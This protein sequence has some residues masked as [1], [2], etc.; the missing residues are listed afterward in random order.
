MLDGT[1]VAVDGLH[2]HHIGRPTPVYGTRHMGA[3]PCGARPLQAH[4]ETKAKMIQYRPA[5]KTVLR[6]NLH[7]EDQSFHG[8]TYYSRVTSREWKKVI[9]AR[10]EEKA[11]G[12]FSG[13]PSSHVPGRWGFCCTNVRAVYMERSCVHVKISCMPLLEIVSIFPRLGKNSTPSIKKYKIVSLF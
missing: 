9:S 12:C 1:P 6:T 7:L 8:W 10:V 5:S 3:C 11:D 4:A 2:T 13:R